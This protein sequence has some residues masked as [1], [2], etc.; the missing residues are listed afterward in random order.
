MRSIKI[1]KYE[2]N[3]NFPGYYYPLFSLVILHEKGENTLGRITGYKGNHS[4]EVSA[5]S[6]KKYVLK[7]HEVVFYEEP[8]EPVMTL[9]EVET[10]A[11][12]YINKYRKAILVDDDSFKVNT[13]T[14]LLFDTSSVTF[15]SYTALGSVCPRNK[16]GKI[17]AYEF[18]LLIPFLQYANKNQIK[19]VILHEIAHIMVGNKYDNGNWHG[20]T[21]RAVYYAIGGNGKATV[22]ISDAAYLGLY[23]QKLSTNWEPAEQFGVP[24]NKWRE[25]LSVILSDELKFPSLCS[26]LNVELFGAGSGN[27]YESVANLIYSILPYARADDQ[28]AE[29]YEVKETFGILYDLVIEV[30]DKLI[31]LSRS[32]INDSELYSNSL[33]LLNKLHSLLKSDFRELTG[34]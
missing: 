17:A 18:R 27:I 30:N 21:W 33:P 28:K 1:N 4:V 13:D 10:L 5:K 16:N 12:R 34:A 20:R 7:Y 6:G 19:E 11:F 24:R 31:L 32:E 15:G 14:D 23:Y 3:A 2:V 25:L 8:H 22:N 9:K 26:A 29:I